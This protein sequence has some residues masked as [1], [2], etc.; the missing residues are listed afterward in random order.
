MIEF[1]KG[2]L[3]KHQYELNRWYVCHGLNRMDQVEI[4]VEYI[5]LK[6]GKVSYVHFDISCMPEFE[7]VCNQYERRIK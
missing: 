4:E 2:L 6:C 3:C 7:H 1:V 5:C